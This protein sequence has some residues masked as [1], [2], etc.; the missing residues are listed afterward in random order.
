[1]ECL[2]SGLKTGF[3]DLVGGAPAELLRMA[4]GVDRA[5]GVRIG[6]TFAAAAGVKIAFTE[7]TASISSCGKIEPASRPYTVTK[8]GSQLQVEISN[9]PKPLV[10]L[11]GLNN[12]FTG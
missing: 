11:L 3:L 7:A 4:D 1:A 6:G 2:G 10:V 5:S 8:R 12:V 9:E